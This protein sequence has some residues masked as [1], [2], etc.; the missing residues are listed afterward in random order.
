KVY[1]THSKQRIYT[2]S[3]LG[4]WLTKTWYMPFF[5]AEIY[6]GFD[7]RHIINRPT[8]FALLCLCLIY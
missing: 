8:E 4:A 1:L 6:L 2:F 3:Y 7:G 5:N